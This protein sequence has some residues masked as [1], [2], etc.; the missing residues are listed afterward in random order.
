MTTWQV[1]YLRPEFVRVDVAAF[2]ASDVVVGVLG[3]TWR[4]GTPD[5]R[6][7]TFLETLLR[8]RGGGKER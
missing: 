4:T 3:S 8:T 7:I 6:S 5:E 2:E 1:S